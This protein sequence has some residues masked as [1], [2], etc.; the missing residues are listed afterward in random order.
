MGDKSFLRGPEFGSGWAWDDA[1]EYY[2]A[3]LSALT[4]SDNYSDLTIEP[5]AAA[6][7]PVKVRMKPETACVV[8][9]NLAS[10]AASGQRRTV[11]VYRPLD[12]NVVYITGQMPLGQPAFAAEATFFPSPRR[13]SLEY[14]RAGM[15]KAERS[16]IR[17]HRGQTG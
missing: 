13:S 16:G 7:E 4:I 17:L 12:S 14:L 15:A 9:S 11:R 8:I 6:G 10:T 1:L 5:G 2:G 3:E